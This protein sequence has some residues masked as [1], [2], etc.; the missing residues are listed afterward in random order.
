MQQE[1]AHRGIPG[2]SGLRS[3][4]LSPLRLDVL[5]TIANE[6]APV[7]YLVACHENAIKRHGR[8]HEAPRPK[9]QRVGQT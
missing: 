8:Y 3:S 7:A 9:V 2:A 6:D 5:R 4:P 1:A